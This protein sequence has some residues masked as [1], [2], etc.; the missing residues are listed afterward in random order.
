MCELIMMGGS[1]FLRPVYREVV[2]GPQV[3]KVTHL[4][5]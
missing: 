1:S 2:G 4:S 5:M 3:G